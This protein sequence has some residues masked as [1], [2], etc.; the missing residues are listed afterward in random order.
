MTEIEIRAKALEIAANFSA[1][2]MKH[3]IEATPSIEDGK[4][5]FNI[6]TA[7]IMKLADRFYTYLKTGEQVDSGSD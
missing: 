1:V 4:S 2:I 5:T 7:P 6:E 3:V